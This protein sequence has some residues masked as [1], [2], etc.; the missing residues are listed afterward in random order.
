MNIKIVHLIYFAL[1]KEVSIIFF[2]KFLSLFIIELCCLICKNENKHEGHKIA[3]IYDE[4]S[5]KKEKISLEN[6]SKEFDEKKNKFEEL[7]NKIEN[8]ML[9]LDNLYEKIFDET[10]K[11][12]E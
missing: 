11:E 10:T 8:E 12:Y 3:N 2:N 1:K 5:L 9:K 6:S 4:E 7:K